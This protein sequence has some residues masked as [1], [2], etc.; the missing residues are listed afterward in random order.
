MPFLGIKYGKKCVGNVLG[1]LMCLVEQ[2]RNL[3]VHDERNKNLVEEIL[4]IFNCGAIKLKKWSIATIH[5]LQVAAKLS[6]KFCFTQ[7]FRTN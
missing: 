5:V 1:Q 3:V 7:S 2:H 4:Q 6:G